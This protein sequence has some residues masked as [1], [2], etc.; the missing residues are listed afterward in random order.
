MPVESLFNLSAHVAFSDKK[1]RNFVVNSFPDSL[2]PRI[3]G[4][5]LKL[6][7]SDFNLMGTVHEAASNGHID[8]L[9]HIRVQKLESFKVGQDGI[10]AAAVHGAIFNGNLDVLK[11]IDRN[12][13]NGIVNPITPDFAISALRIA[14]EGG[15]RHIIEYLQ[16]KGLD[17]TQADDNGMTAIHAAAAYG[18]IDMLEFLISKGLDIT[19]AD[20]NGMT[21]IHAAAA[22]GHIGV[23]EFLISKGLDI[24]Q[25]D[26]N[27]MTAI[28]AAAAGGHI[29]VLEFLISKELDITQADKNG[30]TAIDYATEG[31]PDNLAM[32][33]SYLQ[34]KG[35]EKTASENSDQDYQLLFWDHL[36]SSGEAGSDNEYDPC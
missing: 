34:S 13:V 19:K 28:H 21:A 11:Y 15:Y 24:T 25:A 8:I 27:G 23:L 5:A 1:A 3:Y 32:V 36:S 2:R 16:D 22:G 10:A 6:T 26:K 14:A 31:E 20:D 4:Q 18:H 35:L 33:T 29:G 12:S 9:E 17:I 7:D 30:M